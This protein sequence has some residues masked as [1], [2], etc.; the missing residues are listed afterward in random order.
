MSQTVIL[1]QSAYEEI[2]ARLERMEKLVEKLVERL[3]TS[4]IYG[5]ERWWNNSDE[6]SLKE[7]EKG[8]FVV[9]DSPEKMEKY[10]DSL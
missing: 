10:L 7:I 3:K 6:K 9:F 2:I 1:T 4:S 8:E 5:S